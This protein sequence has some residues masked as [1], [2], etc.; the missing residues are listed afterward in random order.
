MFVCFTLGFTFFWGGGYFYVCFGF[1]RGMVSDEQYRRLCLTVT[2]V[3]MR[4]MLSECF[5]LTA[6]IICLSKEGILYNIFS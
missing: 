6:F 1:L 2:N 5:A 3:D 4:L